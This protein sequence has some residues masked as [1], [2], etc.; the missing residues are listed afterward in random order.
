MKVQQTENAGSKS[1][2]ISGRSAQCVRYLLASPGRYLAAAVLAAGLASVP[3]LTQADA[4]PDRRGFEAPR[5]EGT[6]LNTVSPI[7][8]PGVPPRILQTYMTFSAGGAAIGSDRTRPF[9]SP[10]HGAWVHLRGKQ[11]AATSVQDIFDPSGTF[12]GVFK[13]RTL[14]NLTSND[15]LIGVANV[16]QTDP[17]GN[18]QFSVCA[19]FHATRLVPEAFEPPC[20]GFEPGM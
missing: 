3:L 16:V 5:L 2:Q 11:Y 8:P 18:L 13:V 14:M 10:Q 20:E 7:L 12:L 17:E 15:E 6:W 9:A 4:S 1:E 19:R